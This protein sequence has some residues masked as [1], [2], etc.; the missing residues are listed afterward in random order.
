MKSVELTFKNYVHVYACLLVYVY[1]GSL[2]A[3]V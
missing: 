1:H 3:L 2:L